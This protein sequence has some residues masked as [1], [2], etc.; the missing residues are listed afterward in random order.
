M[1]LGWRTGAESV[2][3]HFAGPRLRPHCGTQRRP[4]VV[5]RENGAFYERQW[6]RLLSYS[7]KRRAN[8]VLVETWNELHEGTEV[9][10]TTEFGRQYIELTAK[11]AKLFRDKY[12]IPKTGPFFKP[13]KSSGM[14]AAATN[15]WA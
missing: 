3:I 13:S 2:R 4:L 8:V 6:K 14:P 7:L 9:C 5:D 12:V 1:F 11:Y 10:E 15:S